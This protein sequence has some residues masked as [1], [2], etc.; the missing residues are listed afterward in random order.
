MP[1]RF[2]RP[3]HPSLLRNDTFSRKGEGGFGASALIFDESDRTIDDLL[4]GVGFRHLQIVDLNA[5][6]IGAKRLPAVA[7]LDPID[8]RLRVSERVRR[9][10]SRRA[11]PMSFA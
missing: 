8:Q 11:D 5:G 1:S 9:R 10:C 6:E 7:G 2:A 3:P 4:I